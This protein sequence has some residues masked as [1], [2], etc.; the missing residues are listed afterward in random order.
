MRLV[1]LQI[2]LLVVEEHEDT[3]NYA[4]DAHYHVSNIGHELELLDLSLIEISI[5][6]Q[7][8]LGHN[9]EV[10]PTIIISYYEL[11]L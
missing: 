11:E 4:D 5:T 3:D 6:L 2:L 8:R 9:L 1:L 10:Q 7:L